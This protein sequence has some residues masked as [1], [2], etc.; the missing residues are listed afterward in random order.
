LKVTDRNPDGLELAQLVPL[1]AENKPGTL[2]VTDRNPA[3]LELAQLVPLGNEN[4]PGN[5]AVTDR[6]PADLELVQLKAENPVA[7]PPYNN[8]SVNQPSPIHDS[9]DAGNQDLSLRDVTIDG[10]N[11]YNLVQ[12]EPLGKENKPG[13]L[14]VTDRN[15]SV[16]LAQVAHN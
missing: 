12:I 10:V 16:N 1:G 8:W 14:A 5:L 11:G 9:G 7:N 6:N 15:P 4:K 2:A 3:N 13:N